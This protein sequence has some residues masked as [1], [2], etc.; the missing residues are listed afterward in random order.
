MPHPVTDPVPC[1]QQEC[2]SSSSAASLDELTPLLQALLLAAPPTQQAQQAAPPTPTPAALA[3]V[4]RALPPP[5]LRAADQDPGAAALA[6]LVTAA[7][8]SRR[9]GCSSASSPVDEPGLPAGAALGGNGGFALLGGGFHVFAGGVLPR[10]GPLA[11]QPVGDWWHQGPG[12]L[13]CP[14]APAPQ[15]LLAPQHD[16]LA[17]LQQG[18]WA[19]L[20]PQAPQAFGGGVQ[21]PA[22]Y[23]AV[24]QLPLHLQAQAAAVAAHQQLLLVQR[25]LEPEWQQQ[26]RQQQRRQ[27]Q[28]QQLLQYRSQQQARRCSLGMSACWHGSAA[29]DLSSAH[30]QLVERGAPSSRPS[31]ALPAPP[32]LSSPHGPSQPA[33]ALAKLRH[34]MRQQADQDPPE[35]LV[36][37]Q[38]RYQPYCRQV[39][40]TA[41][42][43]AWRGM[44]GQGSVVYCSSSVR[45]CRALALQRHP[46]ISEQ[47]ESS[48]AAIFGRPGVAS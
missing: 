41:K 16:P 20:A 29:V 22:P 15:A 11:Q 31:A 28:R 47:P 18:A 23:S 8:A 34:Q 33:Q 4:Q 5:A 42:R 48:P 17:Q 44:A 38:G 30:R 12:A 32:H 24:Q 36:G 39:R 10:G 21:L 2:L 27:E 46:A 3:G 25:A 40:T 43:G 13:A 26:Q 6:A 9:A 7:Q 37:P 45:C 1:R 14:P 35:A 19:G